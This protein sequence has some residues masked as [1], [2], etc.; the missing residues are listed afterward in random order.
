M[1]L[2][3]YLKVVPTAITASIGNM[4]IKGKISMH[5]AD[6]LMSAYYLAYLVLGRHVHGI[7][8]SDFCVAASLAPA[9]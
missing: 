3:P 6:E 1:R 7:E 5:Q 8:F 9:I 4:A 2:P